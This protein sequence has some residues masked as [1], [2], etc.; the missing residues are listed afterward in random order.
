MTRLT[1]KRINREL[2]LGAEHARYHKDGNWYD[3]L[4]KFP[5]VLFDI[6]GYVAF[7]PISVR[8]NIVP[9]CI[10]LI[11]NDQTGDLEH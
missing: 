1:G 4:Q 3:Q 6:N 7:S 10:I 11:A 9:N 8:M 2:A 5:G